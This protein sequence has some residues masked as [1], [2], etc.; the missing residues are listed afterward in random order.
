MPGFSDQSRLRVGLE[1]HL[2]ASLPTGKATA[3]FC[4]GHCFHSSEEVAELTLLV[5]GIPHRPAAVSMPRRDLF[6]WLHINED[7]DPAGHSYR[8]GFWATL[9]ITARTTPGTV[10]LD[11][12]VVLGDGT[13][14]SVHLGSID[15]VDTPQLQTPGS[16]LIAVAMATF[17]PD[18]E[19]FRIQIES[20]RAQTETRWQCVISD[21]ASSAERFELI[22]AILA[23]DQRFT[24]SSTPERL[25]PYRNFERALTLAAPGAELIALA[26]QD[27]R[28]YPDKLE[29]LR[30]ALGDAQLVY[31]DQRLVTPDGRVLRE[32]L[33]EGRRRDHENL[34]SMLVANSVTGAAA[35]FRREVAERAIPFPD[36]PGPPYHDHWL[37]LVAL[38]SGKVAYV[39]QPL[40]DHVQHS[41]AVTGGVLS[42]PAG[43]RAAG[44]RGLRGAYF[45]GYVSRQVMAQTLLLRCSA[46]LSK[47]RRR[48]LEWFIAG[49]RS[50][51][52][53]AWLGL[54][55]LRRFLG[56]DETLGGE[57]AIVKGLLWRRALTVAVGRA[58]LPG[59]CPFDASFPDPP[60]F[61]QP[62]LR[63]WLAGT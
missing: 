18:P 22:N 63:R 3:I 42:C 41:A 12:A 17:E 38:A 26:D 56:R 7:V 23:G 58:R 19:L 11:A 30:S 2:P 33:W 43:D 15:I 6:E 51:L 49:D 14:G 28:W 5:D 32:S 24:V 59:R 57:T 34:A 29:V 50:P 47:G 1:S 61:E 39:R 62:R 20:L 8:S 10:A 45:G 25:G 36:A 60:E 52:A 27:D 4:F 53:C 46:T 9:P 13:R 54:R 21:D 55:P 35:L 48:A 16:G 44:S 31:S 37:A 40:Y